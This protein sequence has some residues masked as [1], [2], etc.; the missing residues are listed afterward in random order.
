MKGTIFFKKILAA[1]SEHSILQ[2]LAVLSVRSDLSDHFFD[3]YNQFEN[4]AF[5]G[6]DPLAI[7]GQKGAA[8]TTQQSTIFELM[9]SEWIDTRS[10][11]QLCRL[12]CK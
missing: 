2:G 8:I 12:I 5:F 6:P 9:H 3:P 10:A 11:K 7:I 4:L 1:P